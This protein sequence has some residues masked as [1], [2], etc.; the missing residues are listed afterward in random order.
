MH[1]VNVLLSLPPQKKWLGSCKWKGFV[2]SVKAFLM[3]SIGL[4]LGPRRFIL[5]C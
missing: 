3:E 4:G 2:F 5:C 1:M